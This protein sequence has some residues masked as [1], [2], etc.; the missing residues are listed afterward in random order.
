MFLSFFEAIINE[1]LASVWKIKLWE[2]FELTFFQL[3]YRANGDTLTEKEFY[4]RRAVIHSIVYP[5]VRPYVLVS[6]GVKI[7][8]PFNRELA[9]RERANRVGILQVI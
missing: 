1:L 3:R 2:K 8:D 4:T 7:D 9:V 6:E 5:V